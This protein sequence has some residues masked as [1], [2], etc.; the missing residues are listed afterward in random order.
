MWPQSQLRD[1]TTR[2]IHAYGTLIGDGLTFHV[3]L[4]SD[5]E[6]TNPSVSLCV[7]VMVKCS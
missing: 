6:I 5:C 1:G 7:S 4:G 2:K 3:V